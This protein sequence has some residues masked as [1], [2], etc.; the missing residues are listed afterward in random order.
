MT[1][2]QDEVPWRENSARGV[3]AERPW[4]ALWRARD[5][6]G[7]LALRDV[8]VRYRQTM[9]G[10][11]WVLVQPLAA[12]LLLTIIFSRLARV[13]SQGI[14]YPLFALVGIM[15]W[16]YFASAT[17]AASQSLI[18]NESLV[19]KVYFPRMAAPVAA[20]VRP[21]VDLAVTMILVVALSVYFDVRPGVAVLALPVWLLLVVV[22]TLGPALW[23]AAVSVRYRDV[24]HALPPLLQL[25][26]LASPVAYPFALIEGWGAWVYALNPMA[27]VI[28][29]GRWSLLGTPWPGP[30]VVV[31]AASSVLFLVAGL[32]YFQRAQ[33]TFADVI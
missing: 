20:L 7:Y 30:M 29:V 12:V 14:P 8:K 3:Y 13:E 6:I 18:N 1:T 15:A 17:T 28:E 25:G 21:G 10:I 26:L 24:Q 27:G 11:A 23:L 5:L 16:T 19:T 22:A 31:S 4:R 32:L 33:Q 9:L 2:P